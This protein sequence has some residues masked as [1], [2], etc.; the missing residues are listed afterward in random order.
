MRH[1]LCVGMLYN[2]NTAQ[3]DDGAP[4]LP[5][6]QIAYDSGYGAAQVSIFITPK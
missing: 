2:S 6:G 1:F 4:S 3:K 5:V